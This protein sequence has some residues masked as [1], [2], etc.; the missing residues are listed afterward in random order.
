VLAILDY[1]RFWREYHGIG[2]RLLRTSGPLLWCFAVALVLTIAAF[3]VVCL[4]HL[5][6]RAASRPLNVR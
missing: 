6:Q 3:R 2:M 4:Q 5:T 1:A